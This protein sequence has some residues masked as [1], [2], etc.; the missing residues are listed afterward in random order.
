VQDLQYAPGGDHFASVGAD[1]KVF[2]YDGKT[3]DVLGEFT[4]DTHTGTIVRQY[5]DAYVLA[6]TCYLDGLLLDRRQESRDG[7]RWLH[8]EALCVTTCHLANQSDPVTVGDVESRQSTSSFSIGTGV[9][10]HQ[11]GVVYCDNSIVSLSSSGTLNLLDPRAQG[12]VRVL[13]G[14][15]KSITAAAALDSTGT[16]LAGTADGRVVHYDDHARTSTLI[17]GEAHSSLVSGITTSQGMAV[18]VGYDDRVKQ[19]ETSEFL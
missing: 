12:V 9:D 13:Q 11:V 3:G 6:L 15:Q 1:S 19:I 2:L 8:S 4:G 18:S 7:I 17:K 16:F 5:V 14:P 10:N